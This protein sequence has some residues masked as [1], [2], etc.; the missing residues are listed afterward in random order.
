MGEKNG[1]IFQTPINAKF[2]YSVFPLE[3]F[4]GSYYDVSSVEI[5]LPNSKNGERKILCFM[6][7]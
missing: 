5:Y 6:V 7:H 4:F 1:V 2:Q 3:K